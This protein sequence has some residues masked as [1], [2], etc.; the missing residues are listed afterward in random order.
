MKVQELLENIKKE[1]FN[2]AEALQVKKYLPIDVK[3]TI[4]QGIIFECVGEEFGVIKVD[5][6]QKYMAYV[7]YMITTHTNL[8]Y[9]DDDYDVVCSTECADGTLLDAIFDCFGRDAD[10]F[11][12]ILDIM[13]EDYMQDFSI[14]S[15]IARFVNEFGATIKGFA[16]KINGLDIEKFIPKGFDVNKLNSFLNKYIK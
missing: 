5:S 6:V 3:R 7:R 8:E 11:E 1:N 12:M 16:D 10:E 14:E 2:L 9:I 15:T 4:A 13:I